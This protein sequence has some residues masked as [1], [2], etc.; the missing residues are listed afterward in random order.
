MITLLIINV[1]LLVV[2]C[3]IDN[4]S[5]VAILAPIFVPIV[6]SFGMDPVHFGVMMTVNLAIGFV[7]PPYGVNLFVASAISNL[8]VEGIIRRIWLMIGLMILCL[9]V[10]TFWEPV[11]MGLVYASREA[12]AAALAG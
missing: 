4:F 8:R 9:M 5:A 3:F 6:K 10:I 7:T 2:G 1:I 12:A 11:T